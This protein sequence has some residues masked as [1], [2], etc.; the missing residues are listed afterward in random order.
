MDFEAMEQA[1]TPPALK[2]EGKSARSIRDRVTSLSREVGRVIDTR[3]VMARFSEHFAELLGIRL[4]S[5]GL[6]GREQALADELLRVKYSTEEWN[7]GTQREFQV[8]VADRSEYGVI[9]LSADMEGITIRK[10]RISGDL[11]IND[12]NELDRLERCLAGVS[13]QEAR[14]AAEAA[15]LPAGIRESLVRL[16]NKLVPEATGMPLID[17]KE[18]PS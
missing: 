18:K 9:S 17:P 8:N 15:S 10:A 2:F 14:S 11:L 5:A 3:E 13:A 4:V 16:L 12:R 1:L 6:T 7:F